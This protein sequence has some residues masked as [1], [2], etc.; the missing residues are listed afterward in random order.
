MPHLDTCLGMLRRLIA[1]GHLNVTL[2]KARIS[3]LRL[4]QQDVLDQR[5]AVLGAPRAFAEV[6]N[7]Y[8]EKKTRGG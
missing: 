6:V 4:I 5:N 1:K 8:I 7:D 3:G 2:E